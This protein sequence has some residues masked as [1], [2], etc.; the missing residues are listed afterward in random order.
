MILTTDAQVAFK[1]DVIKKYPDEACGLVIGGKYYACT[2]ALPDTDT[3]DGKEV[4]PRQGG[5]KIDAKE[6]LALTTAHG[7]ATAVLHS[8][9]YKLYDSKVFLKE[10]R[11]P[12]WPSVQDQTSFI[13]D[14][15]DWGIVA[16]D[17]QGISDYCWLTNTPQSFD[18]RSFEWFASDCYTIVRDWHKL[19]GVGDLP[20]FPR[21]FAFWKD[22]INSPDADTIENAIKSLKTITIIPREKVQVGDM[23]CFT[24]GSTH[25]NHLGVIT[26]TDKMLHQPVHRYAVTETWSA[27]LH[28]A[29]YGVRFSK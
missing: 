11:K 15:C 12:Q 1:E 8:H 2:N 13:A 28:K 22:P 18:K 20:N 26:D 6:R 4:K 17:G 27:W 25:I 3:V 21:K 9:P 16:T 10:L 23:V 14:D 24:M 29:K 19:N 7:P 5:F